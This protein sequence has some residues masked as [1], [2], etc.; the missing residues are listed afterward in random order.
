MASTCCHNHVHDQGILP[1]CCQAGACMGHPPPPPQWSTEG[2]NQRNVSLCGKPVGLYLV[3]LL[4]SF[5][6]PIWVQDEIGVE[7]E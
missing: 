4:P 3:S 5:S 6:S 2:R 7:M 1:A